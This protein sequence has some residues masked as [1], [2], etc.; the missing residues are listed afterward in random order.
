MKLF[1]NICRMVCAM[2]LLLVVGCVDENYRIDQVDTEVTIGAGTTLP[3]GSLERM[4]ID[5]LLKD[6]EGL[7]T[8]LTQKDGRYVLGIGS[9]GVYNVGGIEHIIDIPKVG[10]EFTV[11]YPDFDFTDYAVQ[12]DEYLEITP[13]LNDVSIPNGYVT[14]VAEGLTI[15]GIDEDAFS[16]KLSYAVPE[17]LSDVKRIYLKPTQQGNPGARVD[18]RFLLNELGDVNNGG[19]VTLGLNVPDGYRL[20]DADGQAITN[21]EFAIAEGFEAGENELQF[22]AYVESI[23]NEKPVEN[24]AIEFEVALEYHLSFEM[25][26]TA[27]QITLDKGPQLHVNSYLQYEDADIVL[28]EYSLLDGMTAEHSNIAVEDLPD[29][30]LSIRSITFAEESPLVLTAGGLEWMS[31]ELAES[32]TVDAKLPEYIILHDNTDIGYDAEQH[33]L[34]TTL[35]KLRN[36]VEVDLDALDFGQEGLSP[37]SGKIEISFAPEINARIVGGT[38]IKLSSILHDGEMTLNA[39][40]EATK[41]DIQSFSG[42]LNYSYIY[43]ERF[44]LGDINNLWIYGVGLEPVLRLELENPFTLDL[45]ASYSVVP[46][47]ADKIQVDRAINTNGYNGVGYVTI[48][49]ATVVGGVVKPTKSVIVLGTEANSDKYGDCIYVPC[50]IDKLFK[51]EF[52]DE[53]AVRLD[54]MNE[55]LNEVTLHTAD[56]Y[57][58][59]YT[60][61]LELPVELNNR[62]KLSY[63]QTMDF[64]EE[65]GENPFEQLA[66]LPEIKLGDV[67]VIADVTTTLPVLLSAFVEMLDSE[68]EVIDGLVVLPE[69]GNSIVG[70]EDGVTEATSSLRLELHLNNKSITTLAQVAGLRFRLEASGVGQSSAPISYEQFV[71]ATLKLEL[72]GGVTADLKELGNM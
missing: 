46:Y 51:G 66:E 27:G 55:P 8:L 71:E 47:I 58:L 65:G 40:I 2:S 60:Y 57:E 39:G 23:S 33:A 18:L 63:E 64:T 45:M 6:T 14:E 36:G 43:D 44:E 50:D 56:R 69:G 72:S 25:T 61:S 35:D 62:T 13:K 28:N 17:M 10:G 34:H 30:I 24:G 20:Y 5:D 68:G 70:S 1:S 38:E 15:T 29:E 7:D 19:H 21:G 67:A 26:T 54:I 22:H 42:Y 11:E 59:K 49:A 37:R 52:P 9:D 48:P 16:E 3:L 31:E 4:T 53:L 12:I 32:I 41:L